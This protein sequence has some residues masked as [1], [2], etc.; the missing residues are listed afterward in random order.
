MRLF[1]MLPWLLLSLVLSLTIPAMIWLVQLMELPR[2][3]QPALLAISCVGV[4]WLRSLSIFGISWGEIGASQVDGPFSMLASLGSIYLISFVMILLVGSA[5]LWR[6]RQPMPQWYLPVVCGCVLI[7][8]VGGFYQAQQARYRWEH[9]SSSQLFIL[10][11]PCVLRGL[12]PSDLVT[13][14]SYAELLQRETKYIM[15]SQQGINSSASDRDTP[16]VVW[17]ESAVSYPA[18]TPS[19]STFC[20][21]NHCNLLF[22][23]ASGEQNSAYLLNTQNI[24]IGKYSKIHLVPFGEFV[25]FRSQVAWLRKQHIVPDVREDDI[26]PGTTW[27]PLVLAR[28]RIGV[29]ICFESTFPEI[30]RRYALAKSN[31]LLYITNDAWFH[32]TSA[33]RQHF[34]H[35]RFRALETGLPVVRAASTG[36]SGFI[37]PD[38]KVIATI[39]VYVAA[40]LTGHIPSGSAGTVYTHGGWLFAPFCFIVTIFLV[41]RRRCWMMWKNPSSRGVT[42]KTDI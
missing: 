17:P 37:A 19:L 21:D 15:L 25:P 33:V 30:A 3:F 31:Y 7:L 18:Y 23:A 11:Q 27:T 40:T 5:V 14:L 35:A 8:L 10:T 2:W 36:I 41:L 20:S 26:L 12:R 24:V 16:L 29:G 39:P 28:Q 32:R 34:N 22:G 4:E 38:G 6:T 9:A 42:R 1:D 13:S